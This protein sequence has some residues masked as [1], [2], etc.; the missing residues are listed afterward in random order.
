[1]VKAVPPAAPPVADGEGSSERLLELLEGIDA[2]AEP[3]RSLIASIASEVRAMPETALLAV[4]TPSLRALF[5]A[6]Q[7][8]IERATAEPGEG[9]GDAMDD[10]EDEGGEDTGGATLRAHALEAT[11]LLLSLVSVPKMPPDLL[12]EE[13][14]EAAIVPLLARAGAA[15]VQVRALPRAAP[16]HGPHALPD[17]L[18]AARARGARGQ[19]AAARACI[20]TTAVRR[21]TSWSR[22]LGRGRGVG[23]GAER[24]ADGEQAGRDS[25]AQG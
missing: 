13:A 21:T 6:L 9:E 25:T 20:T 8:V 14:L 22:T 16:G 23:A 18:R 7:L 1:M 3:A 15:A 2:S 11:L 19:P 24:A 10:E 17:A 5:D 4:P 12:V